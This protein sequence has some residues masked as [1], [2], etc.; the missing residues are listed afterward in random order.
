[1]AVHTSRRAANVSGCRMSDYG[2]ALKTIRKELRHI[3]KVAVYFAQ[4]DRTGEIKIGFSTNVH[5]R[6]YL[7]G[8]QRWATMTLLGWVQGGP[9]VEREMHQKFAEFA[10]GGEWFSPAPEL[11]EFISTSTRHDEPI[12][13]LS[14]YGRITDRGYD[15]MVSDE[16]RY[17]ELVKQGA[18]SP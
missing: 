7:L 10:L 2:H 1:M 6:L 13:V 17:S 15:R 4:A 14:K 18:S 12:D 8:N 3:S 16:R 9:K 11:L 5:N